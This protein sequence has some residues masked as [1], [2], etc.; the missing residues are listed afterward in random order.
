LYRRHG[1][2]AL[3]R[4]VK[5]QR[6]IK[7]FSVYLAVYPSAESLMG[8][9]KAIGICRTARIEAKGEYKR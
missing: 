2:T 4:G 9:L 6:G 3:G 5:I 7:F 1:L 8:I